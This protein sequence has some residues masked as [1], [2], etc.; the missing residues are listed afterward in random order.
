M[1]KKNVIYFRVWG[2][3]IAKHVKKT[4]GHYDN[5]IFKSGKWVRDEDYV[6]MDHLMGEPEDSPYRIG[7]TS[8]SMEMDKISEEEAIS[9]INQ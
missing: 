2:E 3:V 6:I 5:Y 7:S 4:N 8:V 9:S 1:K